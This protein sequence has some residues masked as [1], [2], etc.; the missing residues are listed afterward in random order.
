MRLARA[1]RHAPLHHSAPAG[2]C[3]P[4]RCR[5]A[6]RTI[7]AGTRSSLLCK[8]EVAVGLLEGGKLPKAAHG[9]TGP[10]TEAPAL[11]TGE[12]RARRRRMSQT[13]A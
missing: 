6:C 2:G 8:R 5:F 13:V 7:W 11:R 3:R 1:P 10:S 4:A 9:V 12:R